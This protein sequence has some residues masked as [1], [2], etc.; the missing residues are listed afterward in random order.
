MKA[1]ILAAGYGKRLGELT[2]ATPKCLIPAGHKTMLEYVVDNLK[3]A[4]VDEIIINLHYLGDQIRKFVEIRNGFDIPVHFSDELTILGTGG[5]VKY[6]K[7]LLGTDEPFFLHNGDIYSEI[8]LQ[9]LWNAHLSCP[10]AVATV[11]VMNRKTSRP[12]I[13]GGNGCLVGWE[14]KENNVGSVIE[15]SNEN[16]KLA[17]SGIQVISPKLFDYIDADEGEFSI[18]ASYM[19]AARAGECIQGFRVDDQYWIDMGT[20]EKLAELRQRVAG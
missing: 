17:F 1:M 2:Q 14:S 19:R 6:A 7:K 18:I 13:F 15:S 3:S 9:A 11:A 4:G 10:P 20:P 12:L 16:Q 5:G 8:N